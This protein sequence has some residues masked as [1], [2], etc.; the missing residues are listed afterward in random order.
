[1]RAIGARPILGCFSQ[2]DESKRAKKTLELAISQIKSER[3]EKMLELTLS[4]VFSGLDESKKAKKPTLDL[5]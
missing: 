5:S 3:A 4:Q 1:M 2:S